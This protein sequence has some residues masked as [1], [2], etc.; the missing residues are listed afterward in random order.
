MDVSLLLTSHLYGSTIGALILIA[1][2]KL[3]RLVPDV[4]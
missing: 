1:G 2:E 4:D 3:N